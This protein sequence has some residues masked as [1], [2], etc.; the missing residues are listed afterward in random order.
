M[1][2][3]YEKM[4]NCFVLKPIQTEWIWRIVIQF[5]WD[6]VH[7]CV[8]YTVYT[9]MKMLF[10][11]FIFILFIFYLIHVTRAQLI[12]LLN[13][14]KVEEALRVLKLFDKDND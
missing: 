2:L 1:S 7:F 4:S 13:D 3:D 5:C 8:L 10:I 12:D 6:K 14:G 9:I 11:A